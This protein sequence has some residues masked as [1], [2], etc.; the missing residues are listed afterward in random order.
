MYK[1]V[2][3]IFLFYIHYQLTFFQDLRHEMFLILGL[4]ICSIVLILSE[5]FLLYKI[6]FE[7]ANARVES[8]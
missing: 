2:F 4:K 1:I 8:P 3:L 5:A 6:V 7:R